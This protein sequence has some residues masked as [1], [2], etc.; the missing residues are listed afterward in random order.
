MPMFWSPEPGNLLALC[1]KGLCRCDIKDF[2][3]GKLPWIIQVDPSS[4]HRFLKQKKFPSSTQRKGDVT[5]EKMVSEATL[6]A[7]KMEER[8]I[9]HRMW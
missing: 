5:T 7:L 8:T 9:S 4:S 2:E 6:L 3:M 1:P